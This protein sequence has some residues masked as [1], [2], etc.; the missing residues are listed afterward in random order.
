VPSRGEV[1]ECRELRR[2]VEELVGRINGRFTDPGGNDPVHYL[3]RR[4]P[5]E[6]LLA[7]YRLAD[8][9]PVTPL[10]PTA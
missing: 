2:K 4:V 9:C 6:R 5:Y 3:Y 8:V 10:G 1:R 7:Y